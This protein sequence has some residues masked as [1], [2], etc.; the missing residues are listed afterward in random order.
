MTGIALEHDVDEDE[1]FAGLLH[2]P[3]EDS[4]DVQAVRAL[5]KARC[6]LPRNPE[7][8]GSLLGLVFPLPGA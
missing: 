8:L 5:K 6:S 7:G 1:A 4:G 3:A 2:D